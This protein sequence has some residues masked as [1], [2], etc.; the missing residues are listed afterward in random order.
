MSLEAQ[1]ENHKFVFT[2]AR[3]FRI[4]G[5]ISPKGEI[6]VVEEE[7]FAVICPK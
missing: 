2:A 1:G 4:E 6:T 3:G 7:P 5:T